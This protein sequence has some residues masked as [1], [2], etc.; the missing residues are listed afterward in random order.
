MLTYSVIVCIMGRTHKVRDS[1]PVVD[2]IPFVEVSV[3]NCQVCVVGLHSTIL[4][5]R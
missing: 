2:R 5:S 4:S 1:N 3:I